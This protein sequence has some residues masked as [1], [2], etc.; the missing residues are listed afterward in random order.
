MISKTSTATPHFFA[1]LAKVGHYLSAWQVLKKSVRENILGANVLREES[2]TIMNFVLRVKFSKCYG[3]HLGHC[4][5]KSN[6]LKQNRM[7]VFDER[8]RPEYPEK[9]CS[10]QSREPTN[11]AHL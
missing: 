1:F 3:A 11:S 10:E 4:S 8:G 2:E 7:L 6:K 5:L 9:N